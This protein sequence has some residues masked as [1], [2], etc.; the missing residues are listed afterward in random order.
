MKFFLSMFLLFSFAVTF[1]AQVVEFEKPEHWCSYE[2]TEDDMKKLAEFQRWYYEE[3]NSRDVR[4]DKAYMPLVVHVIRNFD[5]GSSVSMNRV[6][7]LI[8]D[9]NNQYDQTGAE[10]FF[11]IQEIKFI[12]NSNWN[13][14]NGG[15]FVSNLIGFKIPSALNAY[16][17][18][19]ANTS[20]L[21]GVYIG[22]ATSGG[23]PGQ[24]DVVFMAN[25]CLGPNSTTWAHEF[26]HYLS[27]PH[28][29]FGWEGTDYSCGSTAP[30]TVN[31]NRQSQLADGSNCQN[32]GDGLCDTGPDYL[33]FR[34]NCSNSTLGT[35]NCN[36]VDN[37]GTSFT[38]SSGKNFMSYANDACTG[39]FSNDQI[40]AM[41]HNINTYR[42]FMKRTEAQ[43]N[44]LWPGPITETATLLSPVGGQFEELFNYVEFH[45][46]A[47]PNATH[48]IIQISPISNFNIITTEQVVET[49]Y[50]L[51]TALEPNRANYFWRVRPYNM[52]ST[53]SF[54]SASGNFSTG[55]VVNTNAPVLDENKVSITPNPV[56][57]GTE[58]QIEI[59]SI[60]G[61]E[62]N[63]R[64]YNVAGQLVYNK[65]N[66][67]VTPGTTVFMIPTVDFASGA[68]IVSVE[69]SQSISNHKVMISR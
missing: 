5:G 58:F 21:C 68:Y 30:Q 45:W 14:W 65:D 19:N 23:T 40:Q 2:P 38:N 33:S 63:I 43:F 15:A 22:N 50:Y 29:F 31:F 20:E 66:Q 3:G 41:H 54:F 57:S 49:N 24:P 13:N 67:S 52:G 51:E 28:T 10:I 59:N 46:E 25:G 42:S 48:Y 64:V 32:S 1:Y 37:A 69:S 12:N 36:H 53:C 18:G 44:E 55:T 35:S 61:D 34:W 62:V 26:G 17:I 8:C 27:L 4:N 16:L 7:N 60:T 56:S 9:L 47:I 6:I 11:Y 39:V